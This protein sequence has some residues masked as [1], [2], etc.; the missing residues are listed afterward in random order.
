[1]RNSNYCI[2]IFYLV[3]ECFDKRSSKMR[4]YLSTIK[5]NTL[6]CWRLIARSRT[7]YFYQKS[8]L[9]F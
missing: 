2:W 9:I 8:A 3:F 6:L 1:M 7:F 5:V 4:F